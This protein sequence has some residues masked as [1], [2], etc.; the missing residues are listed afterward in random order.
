[1]TRPAYPTDLTDLEWIL[2][3]PLIPDAKSGGRPRDT[4]IRE[5]LNAIFYV[6]RTGCGWRHLPHDFPPHGTVYGY[7]RE[8]RDTGVWQSMNDQLREAVRE[9]EEHEAQASAGSI[10]SQTIKATA[11]SGERGYDGAKKTT[12]RKR[13]ALVDTLG[14]L[15][16][17]FVTRANVDERAGA[18]QLLGSVSSLITQ[19]LELIWA[20]GGFSGKD[21]T[22]WIYDTYGIEIEIVKRPD[23]TKGF[24]LLPRRWVVERTFG[25]LTLF[26][27]LRCEYEVLTASSEAFIYAAMSRLMLRRLARHESVFV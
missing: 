16:A 14:L 8:W 6:D 23:G 11:I 27:R 25:W 7:F 17:V 19:H 20:D 9:Q 4:D 22:K 3:E 24:I 21:F 26:R 5:I 13:F 1:M 15:I 2:I 10:D 12:G 18:R